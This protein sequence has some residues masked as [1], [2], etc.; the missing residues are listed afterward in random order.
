MQAAVAEAEMAAL[1]PNLK[2]SFGCCSWLVVAVAYDYDWKK[3]QRQ[4]RMM[5]P[6]L[7]RL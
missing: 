6:P 3:N 5:P 1:V 4:L 7:V 2:L